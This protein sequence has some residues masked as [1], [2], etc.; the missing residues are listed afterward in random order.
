M[1]KPVNIGYPINS[2][3]DDVGFFVSMDGK[4]GFFASNKLQGFGGWDLYSF[5][6]Y[7]EARPQKIMLVKGSVQ[8]DGLDTITR[9][10]LN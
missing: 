3:D 10:V 1:G 9:P 5:D 8:A 7:P 4:L 6:L 2:K